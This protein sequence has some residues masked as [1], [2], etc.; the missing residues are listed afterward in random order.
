MF[1]NYR[2]RQLYCRHLSD[3]NIYTQRCVKQ[4]HVA[5]SP[6]AILKHS[7]LGDCFERAN[8]TLHLR[9]RFTYALKIAG[10]KRRSMW[11]RT[12]PWAWL[13]LERWVVDAAA[14]SLLP[15]GCHG[16]QHCF[17]L[18]TTGF[19]KNLV[20]HPSALLTTTGSDECLML[21]LAPIGGLK[22]LF[23]VQMEIKNRS[24]QST[25]KFCLPLSTLSVDPL[26]D[27]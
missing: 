7:F 21:Q 25:S 17:V 10:A 22:L 14:E 12:H 6:A 13:L 20:K 24:V 18:L 19:G 1:P 2:T 5:S 27:G 8:I 15:E 23:P 11:F 3:N 4:K 16:R 26:S 9:I